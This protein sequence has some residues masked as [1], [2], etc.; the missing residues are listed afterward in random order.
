MSGEDVSEYS[1]GFTCLIARPRPIHAKYD[2]PARISL[3]DFPVIENAGCTRTGPLKNADS[4]SESWASSYFP[5]RNGTAE[6]P[7]R[8]LKGGP[9]TRVFGDGTRQRVEEPARQATAAPF[10][11]RPLRTGL[12]STIVNGLS[13]VL[14]WSRPATDNALSCTNVA[15]NKDRR[16]VMLSSRASWP[17]AT[18]QTCEH[19]R[20]ADW[21]SL[22]FAEHGAGVSIAPGAF[23]GRGGV[24]T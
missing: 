8:A 22:D 6:L 9:P 16:V 17:S 11:P 3:H 12:P 21:K 15:V 18:A 14:S 2:R 10:R 5:I 1:F 20:P 4:G 24:H 19:A 23:A 7:C 13:D